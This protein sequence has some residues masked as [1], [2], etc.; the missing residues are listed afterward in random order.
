MARRKGNVKFRVGI[1]V[2]G[3]VVCLFSY[4]L[5]LGGSHSYFNLVSKY[6]VKFATVDGLFVGS[7][8]KINGIPAGNV[9]DINFLP[10]TGDIQVVISIL[11]KFTEF[12]TDNSSAHLATK[13][14]LGD[15]YIAIKTSG[16]KGQKLPK[17]S[18]IS[19]APASGLLSALKGEGNKGTEI[20]SEV[21]V[22]MQSLNSEK[23][24]KKLSK[25]INNFSGVL[26]KSNSKDLSQ[27]LKR[28][29]SILKKVDE[30]EGTAGALINNRNLYNRVLTLLGKRSYNKYLPSL[31]DEKKNK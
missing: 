4:I 29:N 7:V 6:N 28:L 20:M 2:L 27:I 14:F 24:I 5:L 1:F 16:R 15:K 8:V 18:Y 21:L 3:G 9:T 10:E 30:G 22:L 19:T 12:I 17:G 25:A 11:R 13:G 26:S 31:V 23:T